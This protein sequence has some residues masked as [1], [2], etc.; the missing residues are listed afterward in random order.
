M[1]ALVA[2]VSAFALVC[3]SFM[4]IAFGVWLINDIRNRK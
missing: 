1:N 4:A 3:C 2:G